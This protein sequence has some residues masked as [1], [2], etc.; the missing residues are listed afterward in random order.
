LAESLTR[1]QRSAQSPKVEVAMPESGAAAGGCAAGFEGAVRGCCARAG[2][3]N[4]RN[5]QPT[6]E[7]ERRAIGEKPSTDALGLI[8][9][10]F[11][12]KIEKSTFR[13]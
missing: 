5:V 6:K 1:W 8:F 10:S 12:P 9:A 7:V 11:Y 3:A 13:K 4:R 2:A